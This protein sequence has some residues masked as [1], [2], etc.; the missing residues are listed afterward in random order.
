VLDSRVPT[1]FSWLGVTQY[2]TKAAVD[3]TLH[4]LLSMPRRSELAMEFIL[5]PDSWTPEE[6]DFL[7]QVVHLALE[8]GEPWLTYFTP[9]EIFE[10]LLK[11]GF[12]HVSSL[13]PEDAA[14]RYFVNRQ[15]GLRPP[16]YVRLLRAE[17]RF[18]QSGSAFVLPIISSRCALGRA[19]KRYRIRTLSRGRSSYPHSPKG[20]ALMKSI[21]VR[22][23][24]SGFSRYMR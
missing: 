10:H 5:P 20:C 6:A 12:S 24:S 23:N 1:F 16:H 19:R 4:V 8:I 13:T 2:L 14:A 11:L 18:W 17:C 9:D 15:D 22:A 21:T 7:T 3:S